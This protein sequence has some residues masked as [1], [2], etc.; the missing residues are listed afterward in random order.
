MTE[1]QK[2]NTFKEMNEG[3]NSKEAVGTVNN[4]PITA[5]GEISVEDFSDTPIGDATKYVRP[6]L[7]GKEDVINKFQVFSPDTTKEPLLSKN[8]TSKYWP[9]S[10]TATYDS[11]NE[12]GVNNR[13][14]L[15]GCIAFVQRDGKPS[16]PNF[17][18]DGC[19]HQTGN[20]WEK[21][22]AKLNVKP[23]ELAPRQFVA[24]LNSRPKI[25][26]EGQEFD[27]FNAPKGAPKT[28]TKNMVGEFL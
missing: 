28:V 7:D 24:F 11:V 8:K 1:N 9:V 20:L 26:L 25:R 3:K 15:S 6:D 2:T 5:S 12:D 16:A 13:E 18:Y 17:W 19:K 22:A 4:E 21:V 23:E 14:Y 27:N 10:V